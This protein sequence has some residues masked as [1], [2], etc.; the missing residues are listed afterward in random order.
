[1]A[2][3][4]IALISFSSTAFADVLPFSSPSK[5][6]KPTITDTSCNATVAKVEAKL[7]EF[8]QQK[9]T[10]AASYNQAILQI[11]EFVAQL[12]KEGYATSRV[13]QYSLKLTSKIGQYSADTNNYLNALKKAQGYGCDDPK[14]QSF[15]D[16]I[17]KA[18]EALKKVRDD[19]DGIKSYYHD[20][21]R[22]ELI[23]VTKLNTSQQTKV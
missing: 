6:I 2:I 3:V 14:G 22:P 17:K 18:G 5:P 9:K 4:A 23:N 20:T 13:K 11:Q 19:I 10:D 12:Q 7:T 1:M 8:T 21:L 15:K 16:A